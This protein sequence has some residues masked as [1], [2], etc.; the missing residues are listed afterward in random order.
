MDDFEANRIITFLPPEGEFVV[1]NYR[2]TSDF[3]TPFRIFPFFELV[4]KY[5]AELI[6]KVQLPFLDFCG[7]HKSVGLPW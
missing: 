7:G 3:R 6:I 1:V 2:I 4:S 5:E